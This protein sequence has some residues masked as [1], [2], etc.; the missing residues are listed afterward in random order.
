MEYMTAEQA[1]E[2][3]KGL[4]FEHVWA[5]LME[6]RKNMEESWEKS[7]KDMEELRKQLGKYGMSAGRQVEEMFAHELFKKFNDLGYPF[8]KQQQRVI[9]TE[10]KKIFAEV[11]FILENGDYIMLVEV[12]ADLS[13][14][15]VKDHLE[16]I[17]KIRPYMDVRNDNRKIVGA[18]AGGIVNENVLNYAQKR[19]LYVL[20][21][22]G[23]SCMVAS[24]PEGFKAREW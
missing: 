21:Q 13:I 1:A 20:K 18:V 4:T 23:E 3:A 10:N 9:F 5:A 2:A 7:Q 16:R 14:D 8:T 11:D 19:G 17:E 22:S 12:K 6:T 15:D 24:A